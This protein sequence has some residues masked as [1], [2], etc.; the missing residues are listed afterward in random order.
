[1]SQGRAA[2]TITFASV[3][4]HARD[5]VDFTFRLMIEATTD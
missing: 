4:P 2:L 5:F 3:T 1:V